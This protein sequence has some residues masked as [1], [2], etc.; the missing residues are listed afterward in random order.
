MLYSP[1]SVQKVLVSLEDADWEA[2][3]ITVQIGSRTICNGVKYC[4]VLPKA[5]CQLMPA[6]Q[7]IFGDPTVIYKKNLTSTN[8]RIFSGTEK[9]K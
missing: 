6:E 5:L 7:Q 4:Q 9:F 1:Q 2:G 8:W 3:A